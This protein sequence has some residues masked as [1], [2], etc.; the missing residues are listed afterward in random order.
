MV[1]L[2]VVIAATPR[3]RTFVA[4]SLPP[5]PTST[6]ARSTPTRELGDRGGRERLELR[7]RPDVGGDPVD[8]GQDPLDGG[9]EVVLA[10]RPPSIAIRSR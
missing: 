9:G 2:D 7:G 4:S 1:E 6:I 5:S 10:Q 8:R 3:S